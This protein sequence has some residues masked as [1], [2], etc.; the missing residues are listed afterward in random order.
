MITNLSGS[1]EHKLMGLVLSSLEKNHKRGDMG[2]MYK[3]IRKTMVGFKQWC[4]LATF[5]QGQYQG[6]QK[7]MSHNPLLNPQSSM[8]SASL[9]LI[10]SLC[11]SSLHVQYG[12]KPEFF[13]TLS[14]VMSW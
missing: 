4:N 3:L 9:S 12:F 7:I 11:T 1:Y 14:S 2:D 10:H 5:R 6:G 8:A 13:G